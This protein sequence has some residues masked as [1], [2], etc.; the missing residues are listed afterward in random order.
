MGFVDVLSIQI[1]IIEMGLVGVLT[2][3][4]DI[5]EMYLA[6]TPTIQIHT[7]KEGSPSLRLLQIGYIR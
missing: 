1:D 7:R 6:G 5:I 3:Q 4:I 2:I